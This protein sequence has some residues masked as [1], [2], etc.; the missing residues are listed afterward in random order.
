MRSRRRRRAGHTAPS[1]AN[2][3]Q[4]DGQWTMPSKNYASTR[5]S[6]LT[7]ITPQ[8][9]KTLQAG[10]QLSRSPSTRVRKRRRSSPTTRCTS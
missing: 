2:A 4:D 8:N 10:L 5:F 3:P 1:A 9:V 7:E 6:S